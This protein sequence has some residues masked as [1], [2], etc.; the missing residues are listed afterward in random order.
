[1]SI[2]QREQVAMTHFLKAWR[3][4][5]ELANKALLSLEELWDQ[6]VSVSNQSWQ[7]VSLHLWARTFNNLTIAIDCMLKGYP[8]QAIALLRHTVED[9][10][11]SEYLSAFPDKIEPF[12]S[13]EAKKLPPFQSMADA[14]GESEW[15]RNEYGELSEY[16]HPRPA[17]AAAHYRAATQSIAF[18]AE[19]LPGL[20]TACFIFLFGAL[21]RAIGSLARVCASIESKTNDTLIDSL[22][23]TQKK[24]GARR[25]E[26]FQRP[27]VS[28]STE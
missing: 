21:S 9:Y 12:Y 16:S 2:A 18:G 13:D 19:Y 11:T 14:I 1:M 4:D 3:D 22:L 8:L 28:T 24:I 5:Y 23:L 20:T 17:L 7:E 15:W 10:L 26:L 27:G 25:R 6:W